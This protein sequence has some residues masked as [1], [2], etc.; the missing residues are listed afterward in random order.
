MTAEDRYMELQ[1][2]MQEIIQFDPNAMGRSTKE[3]VLA[4]KVIAFQM[5]RDGFPVVSISRAMKRH[6]SI[7][8]DQTNNLLLV[9]DDESNAYLTE[10]RVWKRFRELVKEAD[11][12]KDYPVYTNEK[13]MS[14]GDFR[15]LTENCPDDTPLRLARGNMVGLQIRPS[16]DGKELLICTR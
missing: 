14:I 11:S 10:V 12:K 3:A 7:I 8:V 5:R 4:R 9:L 16:Y 13:V 6:H 1:G 15:R 2:I